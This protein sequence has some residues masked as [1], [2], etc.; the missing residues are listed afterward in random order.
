MSRVVFLL[1]A[2]PTL[3]RA[4]SGEDKTSR[5]RKEG[6]KEEGPARRDA[7][8]TINGASIL[9]FLLTVDSPNNDS[10]DVTA[11]NFSEGSI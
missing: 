6:R 7:A 5:G 9:A 2:R 1:V 3:H 4:R 10:L 11:C 8:V